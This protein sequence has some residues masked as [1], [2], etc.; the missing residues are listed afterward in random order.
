M[1][2]RSTLSTLLTLS[3]TFLIAQPVIQN[4]NVGN[5]SVQVGIVVGA[6]GTATNG[7]NVTWNV[8]ASQMQ[9][10]GTAIHGPAAGT[11]FAGQ[12]PTAT[13]A[14]TTT[15]PGFGSYYTYWRTSTTGLELLADG[16]GT[17]QA[18]DYSDPIKL[19]QFPGN[20]L[21]SFTDPWNIPGTNQSTADWSYVG[22]GTLVTSMGT[23][24]NVVKMYD[25]DFERTIFW[26]TSP[27]YPILDLDFEND[28][29]IWAPGVGIGIEELASAP[30]F[31]MFP[32]PANSVLNIVLESATNE[33]LTIGIYDAQLRLVRSE[34]MIG[35]RTLVD[36]SALRSG[37]YFVKVG[38]GMRKVVIE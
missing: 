8:S 29:T 28:G 10:L 13:R 32:S 16:V 31:N 1:K 30:A 7:A 24:T 2:K 6:T 15:I 37:M 27:L 34:L 21:S 23:F 11:P 25:S 12:Y 35:G 19:L 33:R 26:N 3:T 5:A 9:A 20:Y 17:G 14:V 4:S 22:Y 18:D 36:V 38:E